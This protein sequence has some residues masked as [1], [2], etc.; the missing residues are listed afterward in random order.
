[1]WLHADMRNLQNSLPQAPVNH[2]RDADTA[3]YHFSPKNLSPDHHR[4]PGRDMPN[5]IKTPTKIS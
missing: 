1:M 2:Q 4:D 3:G 5:T